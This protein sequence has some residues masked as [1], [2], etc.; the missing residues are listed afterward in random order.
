MSELRECPFCGNKN[1]IYERHMFSEF[2]YITCPKCEA[3]GPDAHWEGDSG[4]EEWNARVYDA[5]LAAKDAR[6]ARLE[7]ALGEAERIIVGLAA[8]CVTSDWNGGDYCMLCHKYTVELV[9]HQEKCP[10]RR[11][12]EYVRGKETR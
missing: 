1:L 4:A 9:D 7:V 11:G 2:R 3:D 6:I 12:V 10:Y 8:T 5:E